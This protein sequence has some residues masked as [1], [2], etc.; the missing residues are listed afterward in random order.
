MSDEPETMLALE[1][2]TILPLPKRGPPLRARSARS[3][4]HVGGLWLTYSIVRCVGPSC[5]VP[6][7]GSRRGYAVGYSDVGAASC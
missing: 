7:G 4:G 2:V 6:V 3:S 5:L 1:V